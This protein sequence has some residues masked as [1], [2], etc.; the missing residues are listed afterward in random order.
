VTPASVRLAAAFV[1]MCL[2]WGTTWLVIRWGL[3]DAPPL[4][5]LFGRTLVAA[6]VMVPAARWLEPGGTPPPVRWLV[7][8]TGTLSF[9]LSY[10]VVYLTGSTL[11]SGLS[12][13]LWATYPFFLAVLARVFL[14]EQLGPRKLAGLATAFGGIAVLYTVDVRA[15]GPDALWAGLLFLLSPIA[16]AAN[17]IFVKRAGSGASSAR[18]TRDALWVGACWTGLFA[19]LWESPLE[20]VW[21]PR[22]AVSVVWLAVMGT[23]LGFALWFWALD[24]MPASR[25]ALV[26]Y[27]SP[28]IALLL[29][30]AIGGEPFTATIALGT[31]L[32]LGGVVLAFR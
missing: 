28:V 1:A 25:H 17:T 9:G 32:V 4:T 31:A 2:I 23:A 8:S 30:T 20:V 10:T 11:P 22:A 21:T 5:S 13:V 12:A 19:F 29:G 14:G 7:V 6:L 24:R 16:S 18:L 3:Q 27:I 26:S 15:L